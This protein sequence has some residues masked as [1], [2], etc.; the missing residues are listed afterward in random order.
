MLRLGHEGLSSCPEITTEGLPFYQDP[1]GYAMHKY[2]YF[3]CSRC[4]NPYFGGERQCGEEAPANF[5]ASELVCGS[6]VAGAAGMECPK[7]GKDYLEFKCRFCCS[8]ACWFCFGT[9]HF[10]EP[11]RSLYLF[12]VCSL[13]FSSHRSELQCHNA[14]CDLDPSKWKN[15][16]GP[17]D[18]PLKIQVCRD[19]VRV[20]DSERSSHFF[21]TV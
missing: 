5:D 14:R 9:T 12:G 8:V 2:N 21:F 20:I 13:L 10:C 15:C 11:V 17:H 18:C 1:A 16:S 6:C 4:Q 19:S 3:L 7:H